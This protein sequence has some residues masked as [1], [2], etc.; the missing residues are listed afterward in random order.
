[1]SEK[2]EYIERGAL[3][4]RL[5]SLITTSDLFGMGVQSGFSHAIAEAKNIPAA[6]VEPVVYTERKEKTYH[7]DGEDHVGVVC[8]KCDA[9][10]FDGL[11]NAQRCYN[12][13]A[14]FGAHGKER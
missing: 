2:K 6:D 13:G 9:S 4:E 12:C 7:F 11:G 8:S 3:I 1:M 10:Q 5:N 14:H